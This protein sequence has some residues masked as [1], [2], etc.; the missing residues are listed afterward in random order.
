MTVMQ[1]QVGASTSALS[2]GSQPPSRLGTMGEVISSGL[3]G[4]YYEACYRRALFAAANQAPTATTVGLATIYTGLAISNPIA[5]Q[6]NLVLN[7][8]GVSLSVV[9]V[10]AAVIGVMVGYNSVTNVTHSTPSTTLRSQFIGVGA[11][12]QALVDT[13]CIFPTAPTLNTVFGTALT[14][15]ITTTPVTQ[16]FND[17]G[18]S[19][20]LPPGAYA[21]IY[22]STVSAASS[23]TGSFLWEEVPV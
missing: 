2:S 6:V 12:P 15:A 21:A 10:A 5:S 20:I 3:H 17:L 4:H 7:R 8:V 22:M 9:Q 13:A 14:G 23:F 19:I 18:G 16:L 1:G 11:A